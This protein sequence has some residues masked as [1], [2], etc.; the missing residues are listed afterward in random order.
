MVFGFKSNSDLKTV[1]IICN[2]NKV[3]FMVCLTFAEFG[4]VSNGILPVAAQ[5][6]LLEVEESFDSVMP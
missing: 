4:Y 3:M 1:I 5:R 2:K 6:L